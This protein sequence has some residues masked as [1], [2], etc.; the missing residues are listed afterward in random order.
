MRYVMRQKLWAWGGD[1]TVKDEAGQDRFFIDG[2]AWSI[3]HKLSFQDMQGNELAFIRQ[4]LLSWGPTY[5]I[6]QRGQLVAVVKKKLFT[7]FHHRFTVDE[8]ATPNPVDLEVDGNFWDY[9]YTFTRAGRTTAVVSKQWFSW[10]DTYGVDVADGEDDVLIL[11]CT[12]VV[13][14]ATERN[15]SDG[16]IDGLVDG[17]T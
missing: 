8:T 15:G 7:L 2:K 16:L 1:F 5:E 17:F 10:S 12:V 9:E 11:A 14:L 4:R 6:E 13:D 3:G